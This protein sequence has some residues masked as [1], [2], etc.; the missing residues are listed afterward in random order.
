[1]V[2]ARASRAATV[3]RSNRLSRIGIIERRGGTL[4]VKD[5]ER[6]A[7]MVHDATGEVSTGI[8]ADSRYDC[9]AAKVNSRQG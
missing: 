6:L 7:E 1:M 5:V 4:L 9:A 2:T 8:S 3:S